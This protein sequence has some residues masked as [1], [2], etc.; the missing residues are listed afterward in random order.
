M[1]LR[2]VPPLSLQDWRLRF[3]IKSAGPVDKRQNAE[4]HV[5]SSQG[6]Q[7]TAWASLFCRSTPIKQ[8]QNILCPLQAEQKH[9][10]GHDLELRII[11]NIECYSTVQLDPLPSRIK[12]TVRLN[13]LP[14]RSAGVIDHIESLSPSDTIAQR[15]GELGFV[16]GEPVKVIAFG[17]LGGDPMAVEI[18]FTRFALRC[19]EAN[20]VVL[21]DM[22]ANP[23][24]ACPAQPHESSHTTAP[25]A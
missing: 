21:K 15:L 12:P 1:S 17:P 4:L 20:R 3:G 18:G 14:L 6:S 23:N 10:H 7:N 24:A 9:G 5:K 2:V 25:Q 8:T 16:P 11:L 22:P 19:A 13:Q